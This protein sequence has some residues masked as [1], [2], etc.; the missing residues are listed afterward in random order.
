MGCSIFSRRERP[1]AA[2]QNL[3]RTINDLAMGGVEGNQI[4]REKAGGMPL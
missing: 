2:P 3:N 1:F 4:E